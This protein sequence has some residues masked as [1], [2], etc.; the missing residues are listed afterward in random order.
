MFTDFTHRQGVGIIQGV[1]RRGEGFLNPSRILS[2]TLTLILVKVI[3]LLK[4]KLSDRVN[5]L[6][7]TL[8]RHTISVK[9]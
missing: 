2:M 3:L 4:K 8:Q 5:S 6:L 9:E 7:K 1:E